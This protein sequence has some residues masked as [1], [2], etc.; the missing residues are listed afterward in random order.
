MMKETNKHLLIEALNNLPQYQPKDSIW[1]GIEMELTKARK[2]V[3][4][5]ES[6][7]NLPDFD[8]PRKVW[9]TI[10]AQ[11]DKDK[12]PKAK[13]FNFARLA[14]AAA[15]IIAISVGTWMFKNTSENKEM[16][17][18]NYSEEQVAA[19]FLIIDWE[20][21]EDAF[22]MVAE[23]CKTSNSICKQ[24]DFKIMTEELEELNAAKQELKQAMDNYGTDPELIAQ[25]TV[26]EHER[27]DLLKKIIKRI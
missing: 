27:S 8:P 22:S 16:V 12:K 15:V 6:L 23:F 25:L 1:E 24:P 9:N 10:Q 20:E 13:V 2:E 7:V 18:V 11:L 17:S 21:D 14:A 5:Q 26:I 19:S 3:I 4:L